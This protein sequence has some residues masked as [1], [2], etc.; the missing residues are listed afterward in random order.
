MNIEK[1]FQIFMNNKIVVTGGSGFIGSNLVRN[2][3]QNGNS[4]LNIDSLTYAS[5]GKNLNKISD[6]Q[7][8]FSK[9][10]IANEKKIYQLL[11]S[12]KPNYI[13][14]LAAESHVD[15]SIDAPADFMK[16][17]IIGTYSLLQSSRKYYE[18]L[19]KKKDI[20]KFIHVSTDEVFGEVINSEEFFDETSPYKPKSPYSAS[21]A[22][23]DHLARAWLETFGLPTS[24]INCSN[25]YGPYQYPEKLIPK[26]IINAITGKKI[27]IYG[28]GQQVRDW[29]HVE[30]HVEALKKIMTSGNIGEHYLIG[31]NNQIS[32]IDL[33]NIIC[34]I[35]DSKLSILHNK[36]S[37]K[38]L[39]KFVDDRLGH[40]FRYAVDFS[41]LKKDLNWQPKISF[42]DG[43]EMT[44]SW[45]MKNEK[46]W[47][48]LIKKS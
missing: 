34:E 12:F 17:N 26:I 33:T 44:I 39:I 1:G 45:Y 40:D 20:F 36:R 46:W 3:L 29:L 22:S 16:T 47:R 42:E 18:S 2:L 11:K 31:G 37:T 25:N 41:K 48:K 4:V 6:K 23:S 9:T 14:H 32:N 5:K 43:L 13:L 35:I 15:N 10:N 30:D 7:Y 19:N 21:K 28:S 27:P 8:F 38:N 24:V